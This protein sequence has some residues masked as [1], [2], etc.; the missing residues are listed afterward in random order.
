MPYPYDDDDGTEDKAEQ[1][2]R[3][4]TALATLPRKPILGARG[5]ASNELSGSVNGTRGDQQDLIARAGGMSGTDTGPKT[6]TSVSSM[7]PPRPNI[8]APRTVPNE[9]PTNIGPPTPRLGNLPSRLGNLPATGAPSLLGRGPGQPMRPDVRP[10]R[11]DFPVKEPGLWKKILGIGVSPILPALTEQIFQGP[12]RKA[13]RQYKEA[14]GDYEGGLSDKQKQATIAE[15][16]ARTKSL[17]NPPQKEGVTP[18]ETTMQDLMTGNNGQPQI[19]PDTQKPYTRLEAFSKVEG[20]KA[21]AA[22]G[23]KQPPLS[24]DEVSQIN[25]MH[26]ERFQTLNPGKPLSPALTLRPGASQADY[27]RIDKNLSQMESAQGTQAQRESTNAFR[28]D[29]AANAA[30]SRAEKREE[31]FGQSV[32]AYD[33]EKKQTVLTTQGTATKNNWQGIRKVTQDNIDKDTDKLRQ[34]GDAQMNVSAYRGSLQSMNALSGSDLARVSALIGD[35]KF[36]LHFMGLEIPV[37]WYNQ[38]RDNQ[39]FNDL[40]EDAKD[41]VVG[42]IGARGSI[43]AY[44]KAISGT[45]RLT[46]SQLQTE[47]QNLPKPSDPQD[48]A[49]K[50]FARFQ[51][52]IDQAASGLPKLPGIDTPAEIRAKTEV[53]K[54]AATQPPTTQPTAPKGMHDRLVR[55]L[56]QKMGAQ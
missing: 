55:F 38:L 7:N 4:R 31:K 48:V 40:P 9:A 47:M 50:K 12:E 37:D 21:G 14:L 42:Y 39:K 52:N 30:Q 1:E 29:A 11:S 33:P 25:A 28:Q 49:E 23:G 27:E 56:N 46:E 16:N 17:N 22:Q 53:N 44:T 20:A 19:N 15:T 5:A 26:T 6:D 41:A 32:Y 34:I 24:A 10:M 3:F 2:L 18:E 36:K 13:E 51:R 54:P 35:D 8:P 45:A 43:I